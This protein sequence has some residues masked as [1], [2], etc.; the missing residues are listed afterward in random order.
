MKVFLVSV[1]VVSLAAVARATAQEL[2]VWWEPARKKVISCGWE[3]KPVRAADFVKYAGRIGE[4]G[5]DGVGVYVRAKTPDG[6][7]VYSSSV[8]DGKDLWT[9]E[10][11]SDQVPLFARAM[12]RE[13]LRESFVR[14]LGSPEERL[15]WADDAVWAK[16]ARSMGTL[17]WLAK[18]G[19]FRG[20]LIDPED[21]KSAKQFKRRP[22]DEP[23]RVLAPLARRRGREVFSAVF[24]E[25]PE[26]VILGYWLFS[27]NIEQ[28][29]SDDPM[30]SVR[31][32]GDL[33]A[34]FV[35][36]ILDVMPPTARLVDGNEW[37]YEA[38]SR[39]F[40]FMMSAVAQ[41][42]CENGLVAPENRTKYRSQVLPGFG[43]YLDA[44]TNA[45]TNS[46]GKANHY[47]LGPDE[48]GSRTGRFARNL[49][50]ALRAS[51]GYVWLWGERF[52][53]IK[54]DPEQ[55]MGW[56]VSRELWSE[57]LP[58]LNSAVRMCA[59][60]RRFIE[61]D[62]PRMLRRGAVRDL[63][64][65]KDVVAMSLK[66]LGKDHDPKNDRQEGPGYFHIGDDKAVPGTHY[67]VTVEGHG[68]GLDAIAYWMDRKDGGWWRWRVPAQ[69]IA[70]REL[71]GG[72][73][74]G[75]AVIAVPEGVDGMQVQFKL[76]PDPGASC[77]FDKVFLG[78]VDLTR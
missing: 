28:A 74:R 36:G 70:L 18:E 21:Y 41:R 15:D 76:H 30:V 50:S 26:A 66:A 61:L 1:V 49:A 35:N 19:G 9:H 17:A 23:W 77:G 73:R 16:I 56:H 25:H 7:V 37:A 10:M 11:V 57:R 58:G 13:G 54:Y 69:C 5:I 71:P 38:E 4:T 24:R 34:P 2:P 20:L 27:W 44:Y 8:G 48:T 68:E 42:N 63:A 29:A 59:N 45:R 78:K 14:A 31:C 75:E 47:C 55:S 6:R 65:G 12:S 39:R 22:G 32:G 33:W 72:R 62:F 3:W 43:I 40:E 60:P 67:V 53:W 51:G 46:A 64:A 52:S